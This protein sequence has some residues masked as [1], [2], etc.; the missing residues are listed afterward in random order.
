MDTRTALRNA[1]ALLHLHGLAAQGWTV[2]LDN[3]RTRAG[4]CRHRE[5][6]IQLSRYLTEAHTP[7]EVRNTVLH[8]IAHALVGAGNGHNDVWRRKAIA[9]GCTGERTHNTRLEGRYVG[10]C[11]NGH[12]FGAH[13]MG[14]RIKAGSSCPTCNPGRY[15]ARYRLVWVDRGLQVR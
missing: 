12:E 13:R 15:D 8:E 1:R 14:K 3:A 4:Q 9:I 7:D 6:V 11:P 5:R 2:K 10:T